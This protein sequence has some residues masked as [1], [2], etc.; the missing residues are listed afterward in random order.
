ML[1]RVHGGDVWPYFKD[2]QN[3]IIDF[4][5][6]INPLGLPKS[7]KGII[8]KNIDKLIHYPEPESRALRRTLASF[9]DI[10]S[11]NLLVG[12]GSIDFIYLIPKAIKARNIL[13]PIPTFSE[14]E[15]AAR[16]SGATLLFAKSTE[17]EN[18]KI[19]ISK[20]KALIPRAD[21]VFLCNPNNPTGTLLSYEEVL[22]LVDVCVRHKASFV[23]DEAFIDF[24]SNSHRVTLISEAVKNKY[25]LVL[26]SLTKFFALAGLRLG[27]LVGHKDIIE[28]ISQFQFPWN[29]NS[30]AQIVGEEVIKDRKYME[31][32]RDFMLKE[33]EYLFNRLK[34]INGMKV[35]PSS[36]NFFLC[37]L[38]NF[39]TRTISQL[40]S[41][42]IKQGVVIRDCSNF[43]GLNDGFF[44]VSVKKRKENIRLISAL[45]GALK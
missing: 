37:K 10:S 9:H 41:R 15:F 43:R 1:N 16:A 6:N 28:K 30:L 35:Y 22:S 17:K 31:E 2:S 42:L 45:K 39:K 24:I 34:S 20:F 19:D 27:Y 7:A 8:V 44:R 11:R 3:K 29:V 14:Y 33:R 13:I 23:I 18:F 26:R 12:N 32:T 4:S 40:Y 21:L 5:A 38:K 36:T 25:L